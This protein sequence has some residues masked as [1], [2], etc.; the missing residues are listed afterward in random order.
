MLLL[1]FI[2]LSN[3]PL[4]CSFVASR[5]VFTCYYWFKYYSIVAGDLWSYNSDNQQYAISPKPDVEVRTFNPLEH[6]CLVLAS[7]GLWN[8]LDHKGAV[9]TVEMTER[10]W[11]RE[12]IYEKVSMQVHFA[13]CICWQYCLCDVVKIAN[14]DLINIWLCCFL[15]AREM[16]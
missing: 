16:E 11:F 15:F 8:L 12:A 4:N 2:H 13:W 1:H 3:F 6:K 10:K 14:R 9:T 5:P 7:D